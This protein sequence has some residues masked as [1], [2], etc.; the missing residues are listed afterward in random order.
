MREKLTLAGGTPLP[1]VRVAVAPYCQG[2]SERSFTCARGAAC[3]HNTAQ[4]GRARSRLSVPFA[5]TPPVAVSPLIPFRPSIFGTPSTC[6]RT[7]SLF[8]TELGWEREPSRS[9]GS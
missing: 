9:P 5:G 4:V 7:R 1:P 6:D 3:I 8:Q 2:R